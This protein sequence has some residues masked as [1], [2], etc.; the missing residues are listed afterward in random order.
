MK[1]RNAIKLVVTGAALTASASALAIDAG[2]PSVGVSG[3]SATAGGNHTLTCPAGFTC[4]S[5]PMTD[6]G[7][8]QRQITDNSTGRT[9]IQTVLSEGD[10]SGSGITSASGFLDESFVEVGGSGGIIDRQNVEEGTGSG[11]GIAVEDTFKSTANIRSG[12]FRDSTTDGITIDQSIAELVTGT[13]ETF[14]TAFNLTEIDDANFA[15]APVSA[16]VT[17]TSDVGAGDFTSN[18]T[19][20]TFVVEDTVN[21]S[22][23]AAQYKKLDVDQNVVGDLTQT[24][25]LR[26]RTGAAVAGSGGSDA[27]TDADFVAGSTLVDLQIG[28]SVAGAGQFGLHDFVNETAGVA[29]GIDSQT[30]ANVPFQTIS[31]DNTNLGDPFAPLP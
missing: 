5:S 17:V 28:Q 19:Q 1:L 22:A 31:Y 24:V 12:A 18:F 10:I 9:F 8:T 11:S 25:A 3:I 4:S 2:A 27:A 16:K 7:F 15:G 20:E 21:A 26:E 13:G 14:N 23:V 29:I 6:V 30:S